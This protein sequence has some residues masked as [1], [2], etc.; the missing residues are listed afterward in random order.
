M[1]VCMLWCFLQLVGLSWQLWHVTW[2]WHAHT[3]WHEMGTRKAH[4]HFRTPESRACTFL[5]ITPNE[6]LLLWNYLRVLAR[7]HLFD[8][9]L[10]PS[11]LSPPAITLW[12]GSKLNRSKSVGVSWSRSSSVWTWV[13]FDC[14]GGAIQYPHMN[15]TCYVFWAAVRLQK[16]DVFMD[17][18]T[19][20][21]N[22]SG[23]QTRWFKSFY[24]IQVCVCVRETPLVLSIWACENSIHPQVQ[25]NIFSPR[26]FD[27]KS[28]CE[29]LDELWFSLVHDPMTWYMIQ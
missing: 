5:L 24:A 3:D 16:C 2:Q 12:Y 15:Q 18:Q 28:L 10:N 27:K 8:F 29:K 7:M 20:I 17:W 4:S 6:V 19:K 21:E 13:W 14:N 26:P 9:E 11:V 25:T 23:C 1:F 22:K